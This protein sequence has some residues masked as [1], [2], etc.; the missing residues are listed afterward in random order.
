MTKKIATIGFQLAHNEVDFIKFHEKKSLSDWD[1][2][3]IRPNILA[4]AFDWEDRPFN[5]Y[6]GKP[7][8]NDNSGAKAKEIQKHWTSEI[9]NSGQEKIIIF[10]LSELNEFYISTG[11]KET[12]GT[13]KNQ[14]VTNILDLFSNYHIFFGQK[15]GRQSEGK[16]M[17]FDKKKSMFLDEYWNFFGKLS[18]YKI[19]LEKFNDHALITTRDKKGSVA[20]LFTTNSGSK[21]ILLPDFDFY[22]IEFF[23]TK[24]DGKRYFT[25]K[26]HQF[27]EQFIKV[28]INL[29]KALRAQGEQTPP[30]EWT[31][32]EKFAFTKE[33]EL[34]V[35]I[36]KQNEK[37]KEIEVAKSKLENE[38]VSIGNLRGL[39]FEQGKIL[40]NLII[41]SLNS[42]GFTAKPYKDGNSEFDSLFSSTEGRFLGE[43]EG[44][45]TKAIDITK[46]RQ[47]M[48][49]IHEELE[50]SNSETPAKGVL[51]G[52]GFRL[53]D[54]NQRETQ[55]TTKCIN[56]AQSQNIALVATS[57]LFEVAKY[58]TEND[59]P[60]FAKKCRE[61][62]INDKG[63]IKFPVPNS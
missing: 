62:L 47:L 19:I 14:K 3:L 21:I 30:P 8:L 43:A 11:K 36:T 13:G 37:L 54:P 25:E 56:T 46:L 34:K 27:A 9:N 40:E 41:Q 17:L 44:K 38:L 23:E 50:I 22:P 1:I 61:V 52:N 6:S 28:I 31:N 18:H 26:A 39:L 32:D 55:F 24:E 60:D 4:E 15:I 29:D 20:S 10:F 63:I 2:I 45:D 59:N 7:S 58:L 53:T 51:F 35:K 33:I 57:D 16:E 49:N 42:L 48:S 12:S 5:Y